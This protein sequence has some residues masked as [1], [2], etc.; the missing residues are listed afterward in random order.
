MLIGSTIKI[1]PFHSSIPINLPV[2]PV[3]PNDWSLSTLKERSTTALKPRA[4][5]RR[6]RVEH[7]R[8]APATS[9]IQ[10]F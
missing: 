1:F 4:R 9:E 8:N 5:L 7:F 3:N 2:Q 10:R 6:K